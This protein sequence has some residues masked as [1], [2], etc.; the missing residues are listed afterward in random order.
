MLE[1]GADEVVE[2]VGGTEGFVEGVGSF[3]ATGKE[4]GKGGEDAQ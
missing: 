4:A 2:V 3:D 1:G